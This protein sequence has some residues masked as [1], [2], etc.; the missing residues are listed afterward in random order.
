MLH[1]NSVATFDNHL[2][3][4]HAISFHCTHTL[5]H[6]CLWASVKLQSDSN[7]HNEDKLRKSTSQLHHRMKQESP[8]Y[9]RKI[10][11]YDSNDS[12]DESVSET[13]LSLHLLA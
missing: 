13:I 2:V 8:I 1:S 3:L 11:K 7:Q 10:S 9:F 6:I 12:Q 4:Q 5:V